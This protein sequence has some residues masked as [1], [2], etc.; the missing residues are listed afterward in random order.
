M[1]SRRHRI[2]G[3][4]LAVGGAAAFTVAAC[5]GGTGGLLEEAESRSEAT[6]ACEDFDCTLEHIQWFNRISTTESETITDMSIEDQE[7]YLNASLLA[8][9]CQVELR[10]Q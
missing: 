7:R 9:D 2:A 5:G 4:L 10:P 3:R 8:A 1:N 6:C